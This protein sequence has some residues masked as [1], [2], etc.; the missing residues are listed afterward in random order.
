MDDRIA[1]KWIRCS[2]YRPR[3]AD[4]AR[5]AQTVHRAREFNLADCSILSSHF[6]QF[7]LPFNIL[8]N[9]SGSALLS[10]MITLR[11]DEQLDSSAS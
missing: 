1:S 11:C 4:P 2:T 3:R 9:P 6:L 7:F 10:A 8:D 5:S